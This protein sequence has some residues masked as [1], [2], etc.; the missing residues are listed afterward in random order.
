M[1]LGRWKV[2]GGSL[3]GS[4]NCA[5]VIVSESLEEIIELN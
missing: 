1:E 3:A 2:K 4:G 5:F